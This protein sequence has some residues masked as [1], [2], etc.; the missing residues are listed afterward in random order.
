MFISPRVKERLV[1]YSFHTE[2]QP[3]KQKWV[4]TYAEHRRKPPRACKVSPVFEGFKERLLQL[5][6]GECSGGLVSRTPGPVGPGGRGIVLLGQ[7]W[8]R[9]LSPSLGA[10]YP[11]SLFYSSGACEQSGT[12]I[13]S[14]PRC[15][16]RPAD[17]LRCWRCTHSCLW[18]KTLS[19]HSSHLLTWLTLSLHQGKEQEVSRTA[20]AHWTKGRCWRPSEC[21]LGTSWP[22][23][24]SVAF[25]AQASP[26]WTQ[27]PFLTKH[28]RQ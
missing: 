27:V 9:A 13:R 24:H 11:H 18:S 3:G 15:S 7:R 16:R 5:G 17:S 8:A 20:E 2:K 1:L 6:G 28:F 22:T 19:C 12:G 14:C 26:A 23:P 25:L 10:S 4:P 21:A